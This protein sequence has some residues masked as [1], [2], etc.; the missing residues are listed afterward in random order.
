MVHEHPVQRPFSSEIFNHLAHEV[1]SLSMLHNTIQSTAVVGCLIPKDATVPF[2][3]ET[4]LGIPE[5]ERVAAIE[6]DFTVHI[7]Q[8]QHRLALQRTLIA[9]EMKR[10]TG[11]EVTDEEALEDARAVWMVQA[12]HSGK[13]IVVL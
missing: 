8:G 4:F 12:Y 11:V 3:M 5:S 13:Y 10:E 1:R 2:T 6:R 7:A 9:N